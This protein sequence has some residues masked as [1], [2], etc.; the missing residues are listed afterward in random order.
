MENRWEKM[1]TV[2]EFFLGSKI[3][4]GSDYSHEIK[5]LLLL[6]RK[7]MTN[8][9]SILKSRDITLLT[10]IHIVKTMVFPVAMYGCE[11]WPKKKDKRWSI[12]AFEWWHW[13][14][15][16]RVPWTTKRTNQSVLKEINPEYSLEELIMNLMGR[17]DSL[18]KI[19]MLQKIWEHEEKG[20]TEDKMVGWHHWLNG[21]EFEQTL[22][23][24]EGQGSQNAVVRGVAKSRTQLTE[25]Q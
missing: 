2:T 9:D 20:A 23:D 8:L 14:R 13:R 5:R 11:S 18:G 10:K 7:D 6:G 22:G 3:I 16:L 15:L 19:L 1:E 24:N 17:A 4:V 25:Q 12:D 21:Y